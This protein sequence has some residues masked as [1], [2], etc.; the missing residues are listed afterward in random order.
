MDMFWIWA[1]FVSTGVFTVVTWVF[2]GRYV[3]RKPWRI[4]REGRTLLF[5]KVCLG[6][7]GLTLFVF[8]LLLAGPEWVNLRAFVWTML[9][10]LMTW[11]MFDFNRYLLRK[12][13]EKEKEELQDAP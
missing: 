7:F 12:A 1:A 2:V 6:L 11:Q 4:T 3:V 9:F 13:P 8:R 5:M 10:S